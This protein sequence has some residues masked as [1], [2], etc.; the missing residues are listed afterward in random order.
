MQ[1]LTDIVHLQVKGQNKLEKEISEL[2]L[3]E[4]NSYMVDSTAIHRNEITEEIDRMGNGS[5]DSLWEIEY[6]VMGF[7]VAGVRSDQFFD[8]EGWRGSGQL[9]ILY[10]EVLANRHTHNS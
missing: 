5:E 1:S 2:K 3:P 10:R 4:N 8:L 6:G 9:D 7:R